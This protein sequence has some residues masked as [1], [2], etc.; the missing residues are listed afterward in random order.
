MEWIIWG[1]IERMS[2]KSKKCSKKSKDG[3][4]LNTEH[5]S[6]W[7]K[8]QTIRI[9]NCSSKTVNV[10]KGERGGKLRWNG[11]NGVSSHGCYSA[12]Y[13]ASPKRRTAILDLKQRNGLHWGKQTRANTKHKGSLSRMIFFSFTS[14][15]FSTRLCVFFSFAAGGNSERVT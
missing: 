1:H 10:K 4:R 13:C 15:L 3:K 8:K 12:Q 9:A 7:M 14:W 5:V 6:K 2:L 11:K